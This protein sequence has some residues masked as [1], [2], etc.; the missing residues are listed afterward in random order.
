MSRCLLLFAALAATG[1]CGPRRMTVE[2]RH[3]SGGVHVRQVVSDGI[4][5]GLYEE[6]ASDGALR[7]RGRYWRGQRHGIFTYLEVR[8]QVERREV[9]FKGRLVW[10]SH[11]PEEEI[12]ARWKIQF[13]GAERES[14]APPPE[15][16]PGLFVATDRVAAFDHVTAQVGLHRVPGGDEETVQGL[17]AEVF[18]QSTIRGPL[19]A[20]GDLTAPRLGETEIRDASEG[21]LVG[22]LGV[23]YV[24]PLCAPGVARST[25]GWLARAGVYLPLGGDNLDG[26]YVTSAMQQERLTDAVVAYPG[27]AGPRVS[28]SG[29]GQHGTFFYRADVG[30]DTALRVADAEPRAARGATVVGRLNAAVGVW[31]SQLTMTT[32]LVNVAV[33]NDDAAAE[34][35]AHGLAFAVTHRSGTL[36]PRVGAAAPLDGDLRGEV[37]VIF[38][39]LEHVDEGDR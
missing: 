3:A 33:L 10:E 19:V 24:A 9:Y 14:P 18:A 34:R 8:G 30:L 7:L 11:D 5:D 4:P 29:Y 13:T 22:E 28:A 31:L 27:T 36:R 6:Y 1:G 20:Y 37:F 26:Y 23:A 25:F 15:V 17:R 39:G 16:L 12:P 32:E 21:K 35:A 2:T 38:V